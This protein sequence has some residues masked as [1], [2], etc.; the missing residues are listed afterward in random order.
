MGIADAVVSP[1]RNIQYRIQATGTLTNVP[2]AVTSV[3]TVEIPRGVK[4]IMAIVRNTTADTLL[5]DFQVRVKPLGGTQVTLAAVGTDYT[6]PHIP[7]IDASGDLG[8][9]A[10]SATGWLILDVG[11]FDEVEF[12]ASSAAATADITIEVGSD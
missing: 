12:L 8:I 5:S 3:L 2:A 10:A 7:L 11:G 6:T 9:L 4:R 1:I